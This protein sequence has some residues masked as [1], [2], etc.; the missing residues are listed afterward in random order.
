MHYVINSN[1]H[2]FLIGLVLVALYNKKKSWNCTCTYYSRTQVAPQE[3]S[4]NTKTCRWIMFAH[5]VGIA[6]EIFAAEISVSCGEYVTGGYWYSECVEV[7]GRIYIGRNAR[8]R[9]R[10]VYI[11]ANMYTHTCKPTYI[12]VHFLPHTHT[13]RPDLGR[14]VELYRLYNKYGIRLINYIIHYFYI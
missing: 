1:F 11:N 12:Y 10:G 3:R 5:E 8:R 13:H 4:L 6:S 14:S 9:K 7:S 2:I